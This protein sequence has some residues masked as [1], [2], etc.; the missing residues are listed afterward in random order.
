MQ[1][2]I[3]QNVGIEDKIVGP[4]TLRQLIILA[5]GIGIS[6]TLF[7]VMNKIYELNILEYI[8]IA[9]P[10]ILSAAFA[11]IRPRDLS[12]ARYLVLFLEFSI[13][14]KKRLWDH[15]GIASTV[16]PDL[17]D[18]KVGTDESDNSKLESTAKTAPNL[19]ELTRVLDSGGFQH[20]HPV[21]HDDIDD[22]KDDNLVT[23][24]YFGHKANDTENMYWRTTDSHKKRLDIFAQ[25]PIT[26][27]KEGSKEAEVMKQEI[28]KAKKEV[29]EAQNA[30]LVTPSVPAAAATIAPEKTETTA[31]APKKK[32][33]R[34]RRRAA[35][36]AR[37]GNVVNTTQK[38]KPA[39]Y[40][41]EGE[42]KKAPKTQESPQPT[43]KKA[44][45]KPKLKDGTQVGE[46][47]FEDL[48]NDIEIN[49]D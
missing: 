7:A 43:K 15:R 40:I 42:P 41:N 22:V 19:D 2:K 48:K 13:K 20:L 39:Q 4:L 34:R 46:F 9:I 33:R 11:L 3:P 1:Y 23:Q 32:K 31:D 24:A 37:T 10:A 16:A 44:D 35:K 14:P 18:S 49:L 6:Y 25:M 45:T 5:I 26:N 28:A 30:A 17:S 36:P 47:T 29:E 12:L 8:V 38:A 21:E 27:V